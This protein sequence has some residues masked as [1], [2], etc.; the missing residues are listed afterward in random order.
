MQGRETWSRT[1]EGDQDG[2]RRNVGIR[3]GRKK[4]MAESRGNGGD[5]G[6]GE[7]EEGRER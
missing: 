2:V 5:T 3:P 6:E 4:E 1:D 7:E